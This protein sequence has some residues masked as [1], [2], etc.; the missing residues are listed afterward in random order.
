[1]CS[2]SQTPRIVCLHS[3]HGS[4]I[5][6]LALSAL[7]ALA[8]VIAPSML[9]IDSWPPGWLSDYSLSLSLQH[10]SMKDPKTR[11]SSKTK[12][13]ESHLNGCHSS[14]L[15][16]PCPTSKVQASSSTGLAG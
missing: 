3:F 9:D 2:L 7:S 16:F 1:M 4:Q 15:H 8:R 14:W 12:P 13:L 10:D 6:V 11:N 5:R